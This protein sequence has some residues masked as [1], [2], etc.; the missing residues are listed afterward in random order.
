MYTSAVI[1]EVMEIE[2]GIYVEGEGDSVGGLGKES[3]VGEVRDGVR[4]VG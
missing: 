3:R 1:S 4:W 2:G